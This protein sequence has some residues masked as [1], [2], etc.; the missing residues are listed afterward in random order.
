MPK[1]HA[2]TPA[3]HEQVR[4]FLRMGVL[5]KAFGQHVRPPLGNSTVLKLHGNLN[6]F[7]T[8]ETPRV[9]KMGRA[10][11]I[12]ADISQV[13]LSCLMAGRWQLVDLF[14]KIGVTRV[15]TEK[16]KPLPRR[17]TTVYL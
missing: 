7:G 13:Q 1:R 14:V 2:Y 15:P 6:N 4:V 3:Q 10:P 12:T 16:T 9:F 11:K 17:A 5:A 8:S